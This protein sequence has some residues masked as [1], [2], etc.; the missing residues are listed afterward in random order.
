MRYNTPVFFQRTTQNYDASTGNHSEDIVAEVKR[1]ASVTD[2]GVETMR[3]IYG[4]IKQG[5]KTIRLQVA[6][7]EPFDRVRIGEKVYS[8]EFSR[9]GKAFVLSEVQ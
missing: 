2:S 6:H 4:E 7:T 8:V 5:S 9:H 1:F 3:L